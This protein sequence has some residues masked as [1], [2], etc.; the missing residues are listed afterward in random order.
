MSVQPDR[1]TRVYKIERSN[2]EVTAV[3][4]DCFSKHNF[5]PSPNVRERILAGFDELLSLIHI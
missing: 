2:A 3:T 1:G 5:L 4:E